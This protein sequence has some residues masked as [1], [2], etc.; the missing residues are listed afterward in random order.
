MASSYGIG[1]TAIH[2]GQS[3]N[4]WS[5]GAVIPPICLAS[6]FSYTAQPQDNI[7]YVYSRCGSPTRECLETA[8]AALEGAKYGMSLTLRA[9]ATLMIIDHLPLYPLFLFISY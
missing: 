2:A 8:L 6:T 5:H 7:K 1:T 4:Q 9:V 3:P